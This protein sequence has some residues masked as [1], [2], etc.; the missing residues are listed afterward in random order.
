MTWN[1]EHYQQACARLARQGQTKPVMIHRLLTAD[2][3]DVEIADAL[4]G[5]ADVQSI[6]MKELSK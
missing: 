1:L 3:I 4:E 2:T 5:K 6:L